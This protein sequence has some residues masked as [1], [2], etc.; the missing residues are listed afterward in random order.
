[1]ETIVQ[2]APRKRRNTTLKI[3]GAVVAAGI[4]GL[5]A[6]LVVGFLGFRAGAAANRSAGPA[7]SRFLTLIERHQYAAAHNL[8][9][10]AAQ[11]AAPVSKL[12]DLQ[13]DSLAAPFPSSSPW[14]V[15]AAR[16]GCRAS[17]TRRCDTALLTPAPHEPPPLRDAAPIL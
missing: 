7:A 14:R 11:L 9:T 12:Q 4:L 6:L 17:G 10:P 3:I 2:P 1:M 15:M 16:G 5:C 13:H 8:M